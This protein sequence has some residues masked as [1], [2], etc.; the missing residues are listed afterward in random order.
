MTT[1]I[2][3][4]SPVRWWTLAVVS[5]GTFMLMLDLSVV[6]VALPG[7]HSSLH[8]DFSQMQW[9]FD[10]YALTLAALLVTAGSIADRSGRKRLFLLGLVVFTAAS[11][12]CGLAGNITVLNV[13]R[14][15]QGVGAAIMFAVGPALLGHEFRGKE[16][17]AAFSVFGG[18]MGIAAATGPLIGG[19]MTSGPGWRWIFFLN[20]PIGVLLLAIAARTVR[21]SRLAK[22]T[23]PDFLGTVTF[24]VSLAALVL[25]IIRGN[26]NGWLSATTVSLYAVGAV[27][28]VAFVLVA[29]ARGER[30]MFD[31]GMFRNRTFVGLAVVTLL[32]NGAGF[33]VIFTE[34]SFF[35]GV[36]GSSAWQA[37]LYFLPLTGGMFVFGAVAGGLVGKVPFAALISTAMAALGIGLL[38]TRLGGADDSWTALIPSLLFTG[39]AFGLFT[40][41]RAALAIGVAEPARA[42]VASGI[43]ETFQQVGMALGIAVAGAVFENRVVHSFQNSAAGERLGSHSHDIGTAVST[44]S[45]D[46]AAHAA[47]PGMYDQVRNAGREAFTSGFHTTMTGCAV[48]AFVAAV[49][50]AATLR[51]KDVHESA[52]TGIPP[53]VPEDADQAAVD[54]PVPAP[55]AT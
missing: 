45:I 30:A 41:V 54:L 17:A 51:S 19:A 29:R 52:L 34:T 13:S 24:T 22:A 47:G 40:P 3:P 37:G 21:E 48:F 42:G 39:A 33:P 46:P 25:A 26:S 55:S 7:I 35:Q 5:I 10:A 1:S 2:T 53:E 20:V 23:P 50:A 9:V 14:G 12:A 44:G 16:R 28:L 38:L 4:R 6:S 8:A 15:V 32:A 49:I 36:L 43:S 27:G 11:L 31:L 18:A